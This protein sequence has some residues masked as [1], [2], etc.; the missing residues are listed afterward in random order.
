ML[1]VFQ[2]L[3]LVTARCDHT[4]TLT[5][6]FL[7]EKLLSYMYIHAHWRKEL[8]FVLLMQARV[9]GCTAANT[10][11][12]TVI[13]LELQTGN[14]LAMKQVKPS[15]S[16][17]KPS[18]TAGC[19]AVVLLIPKLLYSSCTWEHLLMLPSIFLKYSHFR[20]LVLL[21]F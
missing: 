6:A 10:A 8:S 2:Y 19:N 18:F 13:Y 15:C 7:G 17:L 4:P 14:R 11:T 21:C 9:H 3:F 16:L 12:V 1:L 5:T 20:V